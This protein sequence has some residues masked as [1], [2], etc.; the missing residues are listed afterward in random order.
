MHSYLK[1]YKI[2]TILTDVY[3][4]TTSIFGFYACVDCCI[5]FGENLNGTWVDNC[6]SM[7][8]KFLQ[9]FLSLRYSGFVQNII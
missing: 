7:K 2:P 9:R 5:Q 6:P 1:K 4:S 3:N 8:T